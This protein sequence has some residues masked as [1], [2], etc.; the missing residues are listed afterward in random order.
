[1]MVK[2]EGSQRL[3]KKNPVLGPHRRAG[4]REQAVRRGVRKGTLGTG[5]GIA[6]RCPG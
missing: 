1:M 5:T 2:K 6:G 3:K 4:S